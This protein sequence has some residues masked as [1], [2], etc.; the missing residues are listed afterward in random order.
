MPCLGAPRTILVLVV[1]VIAVVAIKPEISPD[2][3][4][5]RQARLEAG[6]MLMPGL[7]AHQGSH[8]GLV[9]EDLSDR[10]PRDDEDVHPWRYLGDGEDDGALPY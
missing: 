3:A 4:V 9:R 6:P 7:V 5:G 1:L 2:P 10:Q 8:A